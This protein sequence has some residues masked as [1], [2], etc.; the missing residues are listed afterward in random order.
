MSRDDRQLLETAPARIKE[1]KRKVDEAHDRAVKRP[2]KEN[3]SHFLTRREA[4]AGMSSALF[5]GLAGCGGDSDAGGD[6]GD[7]TTTTTTEGDG[8]DGGDMQDG[9]ED[10]DGEPLA[11]RFTLPHQF[12]V[13]PTDLQWNYWAKNFP[14]L[15]I[16]RMH[17]PKFMMRDRGGR[18]TKVF[19][20][21]WP[22]GDIDVVEEG[23]DLEFEMFEGLTF[24]DGSDL[25]AQAVVDELTMFR[26]MSG[27][28][29]PVFTDE[30]VVDETTFAVT[31]T[32]K[33]NSDIWIDMERVFPVRAR[34]GTPTYRPWI[35]QFR[36]ASTKD[37]TDSIRQ[38]MLQTS[39]DRIVSS[40]PFRIKQQTDTAL[41]FEKNPNYY[42][43]YQ[44]N[45]Q[46]LE[47]LNVQE[48][49]QKVASS[50]TAD[51]VMHVNP[52]PMSS[53][54]WPSD[55]HKPQYRFEMEGPGGWTLIF[56]MCQNRAEGTPHPIY[57]KRNVRKALAWITNKWSVNRDQIPPNVPEQRVDAFMPETTPKWFTGGLQ[58][59][60]VYEWIGEEF[61]DQNYPT[62]GYAEDNETVEN[63]QTRAAELLRSE[64]FSKSNG[65]WQTPDGQKWQPS[66]KTS[67]Q[68]EPFAKS[69]QSIWSRFGIETQVDLIEAGQYW[70]A[71][72]RMITDSMIILWIG[73]GGLYPFDYL[74]YRNYARHLLWTAKEAGFYFLPEH[75]GN[76]E[77][78]IEEYGTSP[79]AIDSIK[80]QDME[81]KA[82]APKTIG[83]PNSEMK[84][85]DVKALT[86]ELRGA[87]ADRAKELTKRLAWIYN[88]M[89]A[90]FRFQ[91][92]P[93]HY[94]LTR[95]HWEYP[96][97]NTKFDKGPGGKH[98]PIPYV[99]GKL[100]AKER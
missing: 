87:P 47:W 15:R 70:T 23:Q 59:E 54:N 53:D 92:L 13:S 57:S 18:M 80:V 3:V 73:A 61:A 36:D 43:E 25:T 31:S 90:D 32:G 20:K 1:L 77:E 93:K 88:D 68:F 44:S 6:G 26:H 55:E 58:R 60:Q 7:G 4:L 98:F 63:Q 51:L 8:G 81:L 86:N 62:Y 64:G 83:D 100:R 67:P 41:I 84:T 78:T 37:E 66:I 89:V 22:L 91:Q 76:P 74:P 21:T 40:G 9:D 94:I 97:R 19:M 2:T 12:P 30:R 99:M 79:S 38:E 96:D 35:Q 71:E 11:S 5:T 33:T 24:S 45:I 42:E 48:S 65:A 10:G 16:V 28:G 85:Y 29:E 34:G 82:P 50:G 72:N 52:W 75:G 14:A 39:F 56:P 69:I 95:D 46:E 17:H 27:V 49:I